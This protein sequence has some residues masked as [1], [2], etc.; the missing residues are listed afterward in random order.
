MI[1]DKINE[2]I[3]NSIA[4]CSMFCSTCTGCQYGEI[5][6]HAKQLLHYLEGHEEFLDKNLKSAYRHKLD[7]FKVF[8]RQLKKYANPKCA[9]C[10]NGGANGCSIKGC[11]IPECAKEHHV[12]FCAECFEFPCDKV[13]EKIYKKTILEK[14]LKGNM[15]IKEEGI[16]RYYEENKEK[17]H[18][19]DYVK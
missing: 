10:R 4:P 14:W 11:I 5:S 15:Q 17:P 8:T 12:D 3:V 9:G 19:I 2:K 16:E 6:H 13:N 1:K 7:E 18:Y